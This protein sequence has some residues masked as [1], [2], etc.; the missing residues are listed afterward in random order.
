[1]GTFEARKG[2][3]G[4]IVDMIYIDLSTTSILCGRRS[5]YSSAQGQSGDRPGGGYY[6]VLDSPTTPVDV[7]AGVRYTHLDSSTTLSSS[8]LLPNG[9]SHMMTV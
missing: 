5:G 4:I 6:R 9:D 8:R 1:M 2:R 3:W 7:L